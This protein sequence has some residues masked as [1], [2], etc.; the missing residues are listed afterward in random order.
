MYQLACGG[1]RELDCN[2][3]YIVYY[4]SSLSVCW[5]VCLSICQQL[6]VYELLYYSVSEVTTLYYT[7]QHR[8]SAAPAAVATLC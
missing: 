5:Y 1:E 4:I 7:W 3:Q 8:V 2:I 6:C